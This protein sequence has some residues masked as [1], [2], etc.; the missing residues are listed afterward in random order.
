MPSYR[1]ELYV[2]HFVDC[3]SRYC[4]S[5]LMKTRDEVYVCLQSFIDW[6]KS[7]VHVQHPDVKNCV[8][9]ILSDRPGEYVGGKWQSIC[10]QN[11]VKYQYTNA[12]IHEEADVAESQRLSPSHSLR[13][14]L[15]LSCTLLTGG[16]W[17]QPV[18]RGSQLPVG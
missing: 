13:R 14:W 6:V 4:K 18:G 15:L 8:R 1:G 10:R 9:I 12:G 7:Q 3:A 11:C 16:T 17:R 5:Y 2:V